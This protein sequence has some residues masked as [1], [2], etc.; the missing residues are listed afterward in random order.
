MTHRLFANLALASLGSNL[1]NK[2][3]VLEEAFPKSHLDH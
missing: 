3:K 1:R 2:K